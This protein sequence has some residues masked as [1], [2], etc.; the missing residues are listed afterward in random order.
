M[1]SKTPASAGT[2]PP[3]HVRLC[4]GVT[5]HRED[6]PTFAAHRAE[7]EARLAQVLDLI[8]TAVADEPPTRGAGLVAPTR[9]HCLLADGTDQMAASGA[10][11]RGW[12]LVAPLPFGLA[13][14][15]AINS[16]PATA[17][18][19]RAVLAG[20]ESD[21]R[22]CSAEVR[23]RA[24]R[25]RALAAQARL[26]QLADGDEFIADLF[27]AK[28]QHPDDPRRASVFAAE[29][30]ARVAL[31]SRVVV[32]QSDLIIAVWDGV[33]RTF[34]GGT[35]HTIQI[36]L[37]TGAPVVWI[38]A[39][40]PAHW[41]ILVGPEA[42]AD[43]HLRP[44]DGSDREAQLQ[45]LVRAA[46][47]PAQ[48]RNPGSHHAKVHAKRDAPHPGP[49]HRHRPQAGPE[50]LEREQLPR[51][52]NPLW[53]LYRRIEVVFGEE[54]VKRRFRS[55]RQTY[56]TPDDI[57]SGSAAKL[58]AHARA[59]PGQEQDYLEKVETAILRRFAWADGVSA[60]L[61]DTYRGSMIANFLLA[62]LAIVGG[63]AYVPF[64]SPE[65]K[66]AFA[67]FE[68]ALLC[69]ILAIALTGQKRRWHARWFETRR[70]AEYLRHAPILLLLGVARAPGR[71]PLGTDTSWPEW[72][73]R[74]GLRDVGL[75]HLTLT[76]TYLRRAVGDLLHQHV[77]RQRDYHISKAKRL[78]T[79]HH[80]LD[81][82]SEIL[83]ALAIVVVATYLVLKGGGEL[84]LWPLD[85]AHH[86]SNLFTFLAVLL[87]TF[88]GAI[89]AIRYF[90][91]F[92]RFAAISRVTSE[93]LQVVHTRITQLLAASDSALDYGR[94]ADLAHATDD[95]VVSEIESWQAVFGGKHV[96]VP[97]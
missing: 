62:P 34:I 70:V 2:P 84:H 5:G 46:L 64:A 6:N 65:S 82:L 47:R 92:E 81:R 32:E 72:Y 42:L 57:A 60:Q 39:D 96:T 44:D 88:G 38:D 43:V 12:D 16:H 10:L 78:A 17:D 13:L 25:I 48:A 14:N 37:E 85:I 79:V 8:A 35:G 51:R 18:D 86:L 56:E 33:T 54:T 75:P 20:G 93:R 22:A 49:R 3:P 87:P 24:A 97:V 23:E 9:L 50:A 77:V 59:L 45:A 69:A 89:A 95:V 15:V 71:W 76:Q 90:G 11:A 41:R 91:D 1:K 55:L 58:L 94:A 4:V 80:N 40:A 74:H 27:L 66:W 67:L 28:L 53:H 19:A 31:A 83:F 36:A 30:S 21:P 26:F 7:I 73:A 52:S 68:L 63:L 29:S 61:S